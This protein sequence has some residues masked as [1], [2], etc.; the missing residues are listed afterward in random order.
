LAACLVAPALAS[1]SSWNVDAAGNFTDSGNWSAGVPGAAGTGATSTDIATFPKSILTAS[2]LVNFDANYNLGGITFDNST[3]NAFSYQIGGATFGG[4]TTGT[5]T[6]S[7]NAQILITGSLGST[8]V[9]NGL[10][11][12]MVLGGNASI[13]NNYL[14]TVYNFGN[15]AG[16]SANTVTT[17]ASLGNIDLTLGGTSTASSLMAMRLNQAS[18][19]TLRLVKE[20]TGTW[21]LNGLSTG[22]QGMAGG[23]LLRQG[24]V[25]IGRSSAAS[26]GTGAFVVGDGSTVAGDL[27]VNLGSSVNVS[28]AITVAGSAATNVY[29]ERGGGSGGGTVSG[30]ISMSRDVI[31]RQGSANAQTLAVTGAITGTGNVTV[32]TSLAATGAVNF[33]TGGLNM[34]GSFSNI[35]SNGTSLVT[36]S[37]AI[38]SNVTGVIQNSA[39]SNMTL[40]NAGN[41][42]GATTVT[43]GTLLV[44]GSG[45]LGTGDISVAGGAGLSLANNAT[46]NDSAS[47]LFANLANI[48]LAFTGTDTIGALGNTSTLTYIGLGTYTATELNTFF[49]GSV[50][51]G[52]G[53]LQ[54]TA[55]PEPKV[56][57]LLALSLAAVLILRRRRTT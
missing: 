48:S 35:S 25:V 15:S 41:L 33:T 44:T 28:N 9:N 40:S 6:L 2:R 50:F 55:V 1:D 51:S 52:T 23:L 49:G 27:R 42:Y 45:K 37:G 31:F 32:N 56:W 29:F 43:A 22:A 10:D 4:A 39:T 16:T 30:N 24:Q 36:V 46:I 34:T 7:P 13:T 5:L 8:S 19:T 14:N 21:Q 47:L 57:I 26:I 11:A 18:G 20:G 3:N 38:G 12:N 54:I 53:S 17:A